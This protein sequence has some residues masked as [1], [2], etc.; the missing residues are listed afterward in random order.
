MKT[1]SDEKI[2]EIKRIVSGG[3][4]SK[5]IIAKMYG[6]TESQLEQVINHG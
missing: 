6:L 3:T 5:D 2:A 1:I 4:T